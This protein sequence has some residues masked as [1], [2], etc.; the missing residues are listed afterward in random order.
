MITGIAHA[1]FRVENLDASIEFYTNI[2]GLKEAFRLVHDD[3]E[4]WLV[5]LQINA[6][7]FIELF[8][9]GTQ[10]MPVT[11]E[12]IGFAHLCL[13]VD[14]MPATLAELRRRGLPCPG[15]ATMGK[16]GNWQYWIEDPDGNPIELMQIM[17][18]S[19]Q[20]KNSKF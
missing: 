1:A 15:E 20:V 14:D 3:G 5:Y 18:D 13:H 2:L 10:K 8:P 11:R 19:L 9:N 12:S 6:N 16:D 4:P 17:G 7:T